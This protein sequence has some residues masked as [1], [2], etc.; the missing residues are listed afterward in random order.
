MKNT[1]SLRLSHRGTSPAPTDHTLPPRALEDIDLT[2]HIKEKYEI[3]ML[4]F[5]LVIG[6]FAFCNLLLIILLSTLLR[7]AWYLLLGLLLVISPLKSPRIG[8]LSRPGVFRALF[9]AAN[10]LPLLYRARPEAITSVYEQVSRG[11]W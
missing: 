5:R 11:F 3:Y 10:S 6:I 8:E 4:I 7:Q 1:P 9:R 2:Y